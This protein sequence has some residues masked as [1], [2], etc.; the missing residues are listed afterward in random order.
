ML[1]EEDE[2]R[3]KAEAVEHVG[4]LDAGKSEAVVLGDKLARAASDEFLFPEKN[5]E[6]DSM[7]STQ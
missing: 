1:V 6:N 2:A 3:G 4:E 5:R 7:R